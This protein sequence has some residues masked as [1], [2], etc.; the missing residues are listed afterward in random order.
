[1]L[2]DLLVQPGVNPVGEVSSLP[3]FFSEPMK[4]DSFFV[5]FW[6][7]LYKRLLRN[8]II[9]L[10][11]KFHQMFN[12]FLSSNSLTLGI[13]RKPKFSQNTYDTKVILFI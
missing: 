8:V 13:F 12:K 4:S 7:F 1:M 11:K 6:S 3:H 5:F 2:H 10:K 9:I